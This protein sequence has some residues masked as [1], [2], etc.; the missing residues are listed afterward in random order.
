[1]QFTTLHK[2]VLGLSRSALHEQLLLSTA[3]IETKCYLYVLFFNY[4]DMLFIHSL[5]RQHEVNSRYRGRTPLMWAVESGNICAIRTL[6]RFKANMETT[7]H[8]GNNI[9]YR[10]SLTSLLTLTILLEELRLRG[11]S[12][13]SIKKL[14]NTP[15]KEN[16][17]PLSAAA[18]RGNA[19]VVALLLHYTA[20]DEV[21]GAWPPIVAACQFNHR[22]VLRLLLEHDARVDAR[23][24]VDGCGILDTVASNGDYLTISMLL[25]QGICCTGIERIDGKTALQLFDENRPILHPENDATRLQCR[26]LFL[27]LL[28]SVEVKT[29]TIDHNCWKDRRERRSGKRHGSI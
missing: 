14:L 29:A 10:A 22:S 18:H 5:V 16:H 15:N 26:E 7:D 1:M 28:E 19:D 21:E 2:I 6:S 20:G 12:S 25:E 3:E 13:D 23:V 27:R 24:D 8:N 9:F 17:T 11:H 4:E